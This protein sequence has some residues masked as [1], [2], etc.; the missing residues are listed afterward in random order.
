MTFSTSKSVDSDI[1]RSLKKGRSLTM[2]AMWS[3]SFFAR[4]SSGLLN[5]LKISLNLVSEDSNTGRSNTRFI[6]EDWADPPGV[7]GG[8]SSWSMG[9]KWDAILQ[10]DSKQDGGLSNYDFM[11]IL[12]ES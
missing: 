4:S 6:S 12:L 1:F 8:S 3:I 2:I 9:C 7:V 11:S 10:S 5:K